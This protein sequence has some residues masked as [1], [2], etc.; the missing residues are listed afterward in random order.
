MFQ[1][2]SLNIRGEL[3][4]FTRPV[5]MGII[6]AT[7]DSFFASSRHNAFGEIARVA[8]KMI[9]SGA[10]MIDLGAYSSRPGAADITPAEEVERLLP[11]IEAVRSVSSDIV[12]SVD[13]FRA[14]V[15]RRAI[16]AGADII[17]DISGCSLDPGMV[18]TVANLKVPYILMHMRGTPSTM[19]QAHRLPRRCYRRGDSRVVGH[20]PPPVPCRGGGY[21]H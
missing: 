20:L 10:G 12:I 15:A 14:D 16:E 8:E 18:E 17:N 13:T 4:A 21:H 5:V 2:F 1:E 19:Q 11:A 7:P 3:R 9:A 6:N